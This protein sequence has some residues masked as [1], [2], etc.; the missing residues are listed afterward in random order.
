VEV[1][2]A[3]EAGKSYTL[4]ISAK[5]KDGSGNPLQEAFQKAFKVGPADRDPPDP[6]T[7]K[8]QSPQAGTLEALAVAFT[9]S[10]DHALALRLIGVIAETGEKIVGA[11]TIEDRERRWL[12]TPSSPWRRGSYK[13]V[14]PTTLEDLAGNNIGKPFDVDLFEDLQRELTTA[15]VELPFTIR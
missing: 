8:I 12:F 14:V 10:M 13:L 11:V 5:L 2:P 6:L 1:G 15:T 7:W 3:L 4:V 9:E